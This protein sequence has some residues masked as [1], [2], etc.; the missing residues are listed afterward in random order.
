M[1]GSF[2]ALCPRHPYALCEPQEG[3]SAGAATAGTSDPDPAEGNGRAT[4]RVPGPQPA[5]Q[6]PGP[7]T[8]VLPQE[9]RV[10]HAQAAARKAAAE[11]KAAREVSRAAMASLEAAQTAARV[12]MLAAQAAEDLLAMA[13]TDLAAA[14]QELEE[15]HLTGHAKLNEILGSLADTATRLGADG[16]EEMTAGEKE[17]CCKATTAAVRRFKQVLMREMQLSRSQVR[18]TDPLA[19][20]AAEPPHH[21]GGDM[22]GE[23]EST[24]TAKRMRLFKEVVELAGSWIWPPALPPGTTRVDP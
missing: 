19:P 7:P 22:D 20:R 11:L 2:T 10:R 3:G 13:E 9:I 18:A 6:T 1:K 8:P 17:A 5:E 4:G 21:T 12:A 23:G 14:K 15:A 24:R 16:A